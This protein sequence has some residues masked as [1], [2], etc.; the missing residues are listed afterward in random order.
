[1]HAFS[2]LHEYMHLDTST[3][4]CILMPAQMKCMHFHA[5][6]TSCI[7][8]AN[9]SFVCCRILTFSRCDCI[10]TDDVYVDVLDNTCIHPHTYVMARKIANDALGYTEIDSMCVLS[11][12]LC[13]CY[14]KHACIV[15]LDN[16]DR[17]FSLVG[18]LIL[19]SSFLPSF[20]PSF[21]LSIHPGDNP[22]AAVSEIMNARD[23]VSLLNRLDLTVCVCECVCLCEQHMMHV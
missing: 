5:K 22:S 3:N 13:T 7:H 4:A 14:L 19:Y 20:L 15:F 11:L 23:G 17:I 21:F 16:S 1:M 9:T 18:L 2:C 12:L 6:V 10:C 8:I